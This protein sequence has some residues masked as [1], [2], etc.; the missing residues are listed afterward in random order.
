MRFLWPSF[1]HGDLPAGALAAIFPT[2]STLAEIEEA[3]DKLPSTQ[4]EAL[5]VFLAERLRQDHPA[6]DPVADIIGAFAGGESSETGRRAEEIL[7]GRG[8]AA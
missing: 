7:Y 6:A 5:Y 4:Q 3:V 8:G 1:G 2:M